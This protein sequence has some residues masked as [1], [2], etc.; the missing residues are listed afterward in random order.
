M[1]Q[2]NPVVVVDK[3][4]KP[5]VE[6]YY[7]LLDGSLQQRGELLLR[8]LP[9][10]TAQGSP[11][12]DWNG[13]QLATL[14][15]VQG[16]LARLPKT[17]HHSYTVDAMPLPG[18]TGADNFIATVNGRVNYG[19]EGHGRYYTHRLIFAHMDGKARVVHDY[20]RWTGE[21]FEGK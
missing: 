19:D 2:Q 21:A 8:Y 10:E 7:K 4:A 11:L 20:M 15:A 17:R 6:L 3:M 12:M 14:E 16:Y 5:A 1:A 18:C 13:H 9:P